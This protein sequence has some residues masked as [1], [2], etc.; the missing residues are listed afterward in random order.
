MKT[1][2]LHV[3]YIKF[4][5]LKKAIKSLGDLSD[6]EKEEQEVKDAL[7]VL[8][9]VEKG[10]TDVEKVVAKLVA[11]IEDISK[12]VKAQNIVL[13]PYA[14]LSSNLGDPNVAV[15]VLE[16]AEKNLKKNKF[17]VVRAPFGY[18]KEFELKVKGHPLSELSREFKFEE[19]K[20]SSQDAKMETSCHL[21]YETTRK[22]LD[23][24]FISISEV[25]GNKA[26]LNWKNFKDRI[27][28]KLIKKI[29]EEANK[30]LNK[31]LPVIIEDLPREK[32][33][34]IC[35]KFYDEVVPKKFDEVRVVTIKGLPPEPCIHEHVSNTKEIEGKINIEGFE[36][37]SNDSYRIKIKVEGLDNEDE[38]VDYEKL[39]KMMSK[40][41]MSTN[42]APN[43]LKTNI[44]LGRDL[45]LYIISEIVG[46]G[47]PLFTPKGAT[48][49]REL[50]RF[51]IDEELRRG[52]LHTDTPIMAK[53][54]LYK[55]SGHWQHYKNDMFT[56]QVGGK[57][58]ALRPMTCPFQ[59]VLYKRKPRTYK[60][61]PLR[62]AEV[63]NLFRKEKSGELRGL[64]R[65]WQFK[66]ADA[67]IICMPD[68][69]EKEF[70]GV[71]DLIKYVMEKVGADEKDFWYRFSKWDPK[72]NKDKYIQDPKAWNESEKM[73]KKILDKLKVKY[74]EVKDE[75]A[76]YGPKLDVQYKDVFGKEDTM[77]TVQIDFA[78][79]ERYDMTYKDKD[80][81]DKRPMVIHRSSIG[82]PERLMA[83]LL[84]KTQGNLKTWLSPVQV[85][86]LPMNE[87]NLKYAKEI[88]EKLFTKNIRVELDD[89]E[90]SIGKKVRDAQ[91]EKIPYMIT[92]GDKEEK[93]K[94]ISVR[95]RDGKVEFGVGVDKFIEKLGK[96]IVGRS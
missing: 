89:R 23:A 61:L 6:V 42:K 65:V 68:Q 34:K 2:N 18:Y 67:H 50:E 60:E 59:F 43:G 49:K 77:F 4:K 44:E 96:E 27:D 37:V 84:E 87:K 45:D 15:K 22:M 58:F 70:A 93:A 3:D 83:F 82:A 94:N 79:P 12:Q 20:G 85:K 69:L 54:D 35:G 26:I 40:V 1:L 31:D 76:F 90:E 11:D 29:E 72:G 10:D 80:N 71:L 57:D 53:S 9:A 16:E 56:L 86:V 28:E 47:L 74:V 5:P 14:H 24:D 62:Y 38:K 95:S 75:A 17:N 78:L 46:P 92:I 30:N 64:T 36:K 48:I 41:R 32:A 7:V 19:K 33:L 8:T 66:L 55:V 52:Y 81:K 13:Y 73:M 21:I 39:W 25:K 63:A 91:T 88:K 51:A